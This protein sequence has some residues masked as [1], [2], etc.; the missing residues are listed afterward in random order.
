ME[1]NS[2]NLQSLGNYKIPG[3]LAFNG[4]SISVSGRSLDNLGFFCGD[5]SSDAFT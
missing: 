1:P 3:C 2:L 5:Q 4:H